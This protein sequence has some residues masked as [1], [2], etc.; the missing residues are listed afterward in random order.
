MPTL[1]DKEKY[2]DKRETTRLGAKRKSCDE[3]KALVPGRTSTTLSRFGPP[4]R[5]YL[6]FRD[7]YILH[8]TK[9]HLEHPEK[10]LLSGA[11]HPQ[12]YSFGGTSS[13]YPHRSES[14]IKA[15]EEQVRGAPEESDR[16]LRHVKESFGT[17]E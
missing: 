2:S 5:V 14:S 17:G 7:D 3:E 4:E 9:R 8:R 15:V 13:V 6:V 1:R 12:D 16:L 11:P 10:K